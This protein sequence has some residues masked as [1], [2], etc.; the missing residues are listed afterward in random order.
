MKVTI[1]PNVIFEELDGEA[2]LLHLDGG[3]YYK[4]N[5]SGTRVWELIQE[6]GEIDDVRAAL[7]EEFEIDSDT[8]GRDVHGLVQE[9]RERNLL[10]VHGDV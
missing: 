6:L 7:V 4:L 3:V 9:L 1:N 10:V 8:A 2:V 5:K